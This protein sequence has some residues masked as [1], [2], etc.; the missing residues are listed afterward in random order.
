MIRQ[1]RQ[2]R[3][4]ILTTHFMDEADILG[5]RIA[6]MAE[7]QLR[8]VGSSL[9]LKKKYGVGYQLTIEKND[10]H[11]IDAD[12]DTEIE[13]G[14]KA[15]Q[16]SGMHSNDDNLKQIVTGAV[17]EASL[18]NN[19]GAEL[20]YQ[21]PMAAASKFT[22]MFEGLDKEADEGRINS[23]GVSITTLDEVFLLVARGQESEKTAYASSLKV[24]T[25]M[26]DDAERTARSRMDLEDEGLYRRHVGA[27]FKKRAANFRRDKKAWLCTTILPSLFVFLGFIIITLTSP[28]RN[29]DPVLLTLEDFNEN[30]DASSTTRNPIAFNNPGDNYSCQPGRCAYYQMPIVEVEETNEKY[31]FCG[32][33][34]R[35]EGEQSCTID[36][37]SEIVGRI[38][39]AGATPEPA[40]VSTIFEVSP[41]FV[42]LAAGR[43]ASSLTSYILHCVRFVVVGKPL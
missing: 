42:W 21:L 5:D 28:E 31:Y 38:T 8:C 36:E 32:Y 23:Y 7:G 20:S 16:I 10:K 14:S 30:I 2:N 9:F 27:L 4:I 37:S 17:S 40:D 18:L 33:Q 11:V 34:A 13:V 29:L 22:A 41:D 24:G 15:P 43:A 39:D 12:T 6:I 26:D 25:A 3:C 19:V 35:L 1:Y